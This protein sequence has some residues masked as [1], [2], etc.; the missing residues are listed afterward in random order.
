MSRKYAYILPSNPLPPPF[1][2]W[3]SLWE[4]CKATK[5]THCVSNRLWSWMLTCSW[6]PSSFAFLKHFIAPVLWPSAFYPP[7]PHSSIGY[8]LFKPLKSSLS[9]DSHLQLS[10]ERKAKWQQ[11]EKKKRKGSKGGYEETIREGGVTKVS[12]K[13]CYKGKAMLIRERMN[14]RETV[15]CPWT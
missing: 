1:A 5:L 10:Q 12:T 7:R 8:M 4:G 14:R 6:P 13:W 15:L 11:G 3:D 2:S 9:G